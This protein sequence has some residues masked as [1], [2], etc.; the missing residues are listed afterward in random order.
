KAQEL[1]DFY[2][3]EGYD[4]GELDKFK[5]ALGDEAKR[6]ELYNFFNKEGYDVG[7]A[8]AF[9]LKK[10]ENSELPS[11]NQALE[12]GG[13]PQGTNI[14]LG[15]NQQQQASDSDSSVGVIR[16]EDFEL[17]T[18]SE[19]LYEEYKNA[20]IL[21]NNEISDIN[22]RIAEEEDGDFGF[23]GNI[24]KAALQMNPELSMML[25]FNPWE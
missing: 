18:D 5:S 21:S 25:G 6:M 4:L 24:K 23:F 1:Y 22:R 8:S 19:A 3:K 2:N 20:G 17:D 16:L 9:I 7:D 12:F 14:S 10:K 13:Q 15:S 11:Q